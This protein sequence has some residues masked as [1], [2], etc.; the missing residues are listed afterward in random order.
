[1][2][3]Q[4]TIYVIDDDAA[5]R[6][7][8][9]ML[10]EAEGFLVVEFASGAEFLRAGRLDGSSCLLLDMHMPGLS[11]VELLERVRGDHPRTPV[12]VMTG[13][14]GAAIAKAAASAGA[15]LLEKPF[16]GRE[17]L[18]AIAGSLRGRP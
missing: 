6:D 10:L 14:P 18:D 15:P 7:S 12:V 11:G 4:P 1:L 8:L 3:Q 17:L 13:R 9:R 2:T 16:R 5:V